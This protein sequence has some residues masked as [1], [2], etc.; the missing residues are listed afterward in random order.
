VTGVQTCALPIYQ[1]RLAALEALA[2]H[3]KAS[4]ALIAT[5]RPE[6]GLWPS[7]AVID[8]IGVLKR[9][10]GLAERDQW[11]KA[12]LATLEARFTDTGRRL[13][14]QN[15]NRDSLWWMMTSADTNAVRALLALIDEPGWKDR[16]PRLATSVLG[17]QERGRWDT[18][19]ANA[20]GSLALERYKQRFEAVKPTGKSYAVLGQ[21]GRVI[22]WRNLPKGATAFLPLTGETGLL[23]LRHDGQGNPY[24]IVTTLAAVPITAPVAR[25]Y[26]VSREIRAVERK[27]PGKWSRGD[28]LRVRLT[29]DAR[30]DM[31]WVVVED[32]IPAGASI[33]GGAG[34]RAS[35]LLTQGETDDGAWPAWRESLFDGFRAYYDYL[36]RGRHSLEYTV[37]L[38]A[39]GRFQLP[40]TRVEAMYAPEMHGE[41]PNGPFEVAP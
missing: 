24:A 12:A 34:Q 9:V 11:L 20:W 36:P 1:R 25:G 38:N 30:D 37:R 17:R 14:F 13:N 3:G 26:A 7:S 18:T 8:W 21:E 10:G 19:T 6:P 33:L 31:G 41:S 22:D 32:P 29:I 40:P 28:I 27:T 39:D 35:R 4:P 23:R 5:I 16:L 15:E 2:R